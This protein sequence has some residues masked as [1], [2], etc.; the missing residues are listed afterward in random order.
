MDCYFELATWAYIKYEVSPFW[1]PYV[2]WTS[3]YIKNSTR[4]VWLKDKRF[5]DLIAAVEFVLDTW[6]L[7]R[8]RIVGDSDIEFGGSCCKTHFKPGTVKTGLVSSIKWV[9]VTVTARV[10]LSVEFKWFNAMRPRP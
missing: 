7:V 8:D 2:M 4:F 9:F 10:G 5:R 3:S 6:C 1:F